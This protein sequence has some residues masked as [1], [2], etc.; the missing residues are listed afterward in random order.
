MAMPFFCDL[1][2]SKKK[3]KKKKQKKK[4]TKFSYKISCSLTLLNVFL[5]EV[6]FDKSTIGLHF[7]LIFFMF[8]KFLEN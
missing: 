5:L 1:C 4:K 3:T 7:L 6:N 8:A 2:R